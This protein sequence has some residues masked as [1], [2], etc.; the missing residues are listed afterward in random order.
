VTLFQRTDLVKLGEVIDFD[1][2][3]THRSM[4]GAERKALSA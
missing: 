2:E 1:S 3:V 4:L